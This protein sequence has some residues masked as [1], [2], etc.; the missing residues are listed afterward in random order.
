MLR[1]AA[2][3][4]LRT[5]FDKLL[6]MIVLDSGRHAPTG[7]AFCKPVVKSVIMIARYYGMI[8]TGN[9]WNFRFAARS[10]TT[11]GLDRI[12]SF[13]RRGFPRGQCVLQ[14]CCQIGYHDCAIVWYDCYRQSLEFLDSLPGAPRL[15]AFF[16]MKSTALPR[17]SAAALTRMPFPVR[18]SIKYRNFGF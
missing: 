4:S 8:A 13:F 10:T 1:V 9:H 17:F 18:I 5:W 2:D 11:P 15:R 16:L 3:N 14:A 6:I 7:N 12:G